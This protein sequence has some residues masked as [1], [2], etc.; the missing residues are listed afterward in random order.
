MRVKL[1]ALAWFGM[2]YAVAILLALAVPPTAMTLHNLGVTVPIYKLIVFTVLIPYGLVWAM[3]FYA[4]DKL[5]AYQ[6]T[7]A[8]TAEGKGY[9]SIVRGLRVLAWGL[10]LSAILS[11]LLNLIAHFAPEFD[12]AQTVISRYVSLIVT[13]AAFILIQDGTYALV[14]TV[15]ARWTNTGIRMMI[16][17][18]TVIGTFFLK[19]VSDNQSGQT[20]PYHLSFPILLVTVII[21]YICI[22]AIGITCA[23]DIRVY[24]RKSH[25]VL[26]K[27]ALDLFSG[28]LALVI[29]ASV[30][31]QYITAAFMH[32]GGFSLGALLI[33]VYALLVVE[34]AGL[35]LVATG[36]KQLKRI[37]DV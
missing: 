23:Y 20:N 37:E 14:K 22:W 28:G 26:Y 4:Y 18:S 7:I 16:I 33:L 34:A 36:A 31:S 32:Q 9:G 1:P 3:A 30:A 13:G 17:I 2:L 24:A 12:G 25:G 10:I 11:M 5:Q 15:G 21:P 19:L 29:L 35:G 27:R 8:K 6:Q